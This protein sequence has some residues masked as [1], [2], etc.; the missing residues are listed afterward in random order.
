MRKTM[1]K[2]IMNKR[3]T[4]TVMFREPSTTLIGRL[5][6]FFGVEINRKYQVGY[7]HQ[8]GF[9][10]KHTNTEPDIAIIEIEDG[11]LVTVPN[12]EKYYKLL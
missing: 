9:S 6:S 2:Y 11:K 8:V 1:D 4:R 3:P 7:F 12:N 5:L 10:G